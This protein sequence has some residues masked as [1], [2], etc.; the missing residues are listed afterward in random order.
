MVTLDHTRNI[1]HEGENSTFKIYILNQYG[2]KSREGVETFRHI[3]TLFSDYLLSNNVTQVDI[4][5]ISI[6][7]Q[8]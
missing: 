6:L 7:A 8:V 5:V 3:W 4:C 2:K 1:A